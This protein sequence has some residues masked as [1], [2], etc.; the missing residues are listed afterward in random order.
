[1]PK[2]SIVERSFALL[3][4]NRRLCE[5]CERWFYTSLQFVHLAFLDMLL[6]KTLNTF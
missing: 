3:D 5:N 6:K 2:R 4:K 1:M